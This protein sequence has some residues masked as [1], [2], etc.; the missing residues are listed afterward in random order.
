MINICIMCGAS[1]LTPYGRKFSC[2]PE[3]KVEMDRARWRRS[4]EK[5]RTVRAA[6]TRHW[7]KRNREAIRERARMKAAEQ[8]IWRKCAV[9]GQSFRPKNGLAKNCSE[10]CR[11]AYASRSNQIWRAEHNGEL[12][13]KARKRFGRY[14]ERNREKCRKM[15]VAI[16]ALR[17]IQKERESHD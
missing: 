2:S 5:N 8:A 7:Y 6:R 9:C 11:R 15:S 3:C 4:G 17:A 14:C 1:F 16:L 12:R 13:E 10:A